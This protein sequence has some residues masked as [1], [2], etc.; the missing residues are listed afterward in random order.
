MTLIKF[1]HSN[2][3]TRDIYIYEA[4]KGPP[5]GKWVYNSI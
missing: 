5:I 1:T 2:L 4:V 3:K